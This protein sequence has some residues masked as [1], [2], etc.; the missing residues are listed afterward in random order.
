MVITGL[1][2]MTHFQGHWK[3]SKPYLAY[4]YIPILNVS[5]L[6]IYFFSFLCCSLWQRRHSL[7]SGYLL[8]ALSSSSSAEGNQGLVSAAGP[9]S[10][11]EIGDLS[12]NVHTVCP[13]QNK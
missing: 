2:A 7:T 8:A 12:K 10:D 5:S 3:I 1:V 4:K 6:N 9:I 11:T 13:C